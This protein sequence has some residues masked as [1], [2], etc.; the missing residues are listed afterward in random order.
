MKLS[1]KTVMKLIKGAVYF[2]EDKGYLIPYRYSKAQLD[3]M[4]RDT[5]DHGWRWRARISGG[6]RIELM[7]D[8]T[9]LSFDYIASHT[10]ERAN[11]VDLYV[12]NTL[13]SV[14]TIGERMKGKISFNMREGYKRVCVYFPCESTLR[15]KSFTINSGYK[16]VKDKGLRILVLGDSI[17]QGAGPSIGSASYLNS[18]SRKLNCVTLGQGIGGYRYE[19]CDLMRIDGFDPDKIIVFLGTNYYEASCLELGYDYAKAVKEYYAK[20]TELYP[21][22]PVLCITPL[23]RNNGVD[24]QRFKWCIDTIKSACAEYENIKVVDGLDLV[25]N[26]DECFSD[27]VHPNAYGSELLA[28]NLI[29]EMKRLKF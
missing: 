28:N 23:W 21:D 2:E 19:P 15:I 11:T 3:Y 16:S 17:T 8:A 29:S 25:P 13:C 14:Y 7:T 22:I 27:G 24:W 18:I 20:L 1:N 6:I 10:H 9:E 5:Y 12:N 26:V 4:A